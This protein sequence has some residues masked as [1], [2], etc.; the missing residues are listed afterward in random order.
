LPDIKNIEVQNDADILPDSTV[1]L[2]VDI[3][4]KG[5]TETSLSS[6]VDI[7]ALTPNVTITDGSVVIPAIGA[8]Q[9]SRVV[10]DLSFEVDAN[11]QPGD[12]VEIEAWIAMDGVE[13]ERE[14]QRWVVGQQNTLLASDGENGLEVFQS[15]GTGIMWD[16]THVMSRE[17]VSIADSPIGHVDKNSD[18]YC[19]SFNVT[20]S[21]LGTPVMEYWAAWGLSNKNEFGVLTDN[22]FSF[23]D[24]YVRLQISTNNG[25]TWTN[26]TTDNT[27]ILNGQPAY[28]GNQK[29]TKEI[30]DLSAYQGQD[31]EIQF[32]LHSGNLTETDGFYIDN[33]KIMDYY[34]D[35]CPDPNN[36]DSDGDGVCDD[37]DICPGGDD[38][39][40]S[41]FDEMPDFCD[42]CP[43]DIDNDCADCPAYDFS[44]ISVLSFDAGQDF[45]PSSVQDSGATLYMEGNAWKAIDISYDVT[46]NTVI[47]FDFK[48]TVEGE[49]HEVAF[50]N[51]LLFAPDHRI[52]VYG[53]QGYGGTFTN[54]TYSGSEEWE[55]FTVSLGANFTGLFQYLVLSADDDANAVG[56]SFFRNIKIFEDSDGDLKCDDSCLDINVKVFLEGPYNA[57]TGMMNTDL[58]NLDIL[59]GET[60]VGVAISNTPAGQPYNASPWNYAGTEGANWSNGDYA[61]NVVDWVLVSV[62]SSTSVADKVACGAGLLM[63]DGTI[64]MAENCVLKHGG[65]DSLHLVIE[66]RNHMHIMTEEKIPV[67]NGMVTYDFTNSANPAAGINKQTPF[68]QIC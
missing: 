50:D 54:A 41:D 7:M 14:V 49:I 65:N 31:V 57:A 60:S 24:D 38:M 1:I 39:L 56:N 44:S 28:I 11:A 43:F 66:H 2:D 55:T 26:M 35:R 46:P 45:G 40:D 48:S 4:N 29:W 18:T 58:N 53:N 59:P 22:Q 12:I 5:M 51:D 20:L 15:T 3:I 42:A 13:F 36:P 10:G 68:I 25:V 8:R 47:Q 52:V 63:D 23:N 30:I 37:M 27:Q 61:S 17:G 21:G 6:R 64:V 32:L 16:T 67:V 62:R 33:F 19:T 9:I 34:M